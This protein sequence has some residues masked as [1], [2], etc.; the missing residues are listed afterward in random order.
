MPIDY[1]TKFKLF[2]TSKNFCSVPWNLFFV[3]V[4]GQIKTCT[5]GKEYFGNIHDTDVKQILK[6]PEIGHIKSNMLIDAP[7]K[8]CQTCIGLENAGNEVKSYGYLRNM[9]NEKFLSQDVDYN[10]TEEFVFSAVDLHWSSLCDLKCV[11]CWA[12]QSSSLALE[13][14]LPVQHTKTEKALE[15]IETIV[16]NQHTLKEVYLSGGEPT[17]IKYNLKLLSQLDKRSDLLIRV[18]TNMM[19]NQD[20]AI[21][22]EILKFPNVMFTCSADNTNQRFEYIRRGANWSKFTN[23]L[24]FLCDQPNVQVRVNTVFFVC[25]AMDMLATFE[26]FNS[27]YKITDF[28]INQCSMGHDYLRSRNLA[29]PIKDKI[30][31]QLEQAKITYNT[32]LNL[33]GQFNN[34]INELLQP[35]TQDYLPYFKDIDQKAGTSFELIFPELV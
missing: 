34:C 14:G 23:N 22:Q 6:S 29:Q 33:I 24:K 10:N 20:N 19:W 12:K 11:T 18:N 31:A 27:N 3:W 17:L 13:Q 26:Y 15:V 32:N 5:L 1:K 2:K 35:R 16:T 9:Y 21:V 25:T 8:N 30:I 4:D 7:N 28:T